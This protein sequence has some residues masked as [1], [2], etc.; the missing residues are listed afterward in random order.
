MVAAFVE[1]V[2]FGQRGEGEKMYT[3]LFTVRRCARRNRSSLASAVTFETLEIRKMLSTVSL[4]A[5]TTAVLTLAS[6][7]TLQGNGHT[8]GGVAGYDVNSVTVENLKITASRSAANNGS[9]G[10]N[11]Y[12]DKA[13]T[14]LTISNVSISGFTN[15]YGLLIGTIGSG[16]YANISISAVSAFSNGQAGI[17]T[18][19]N[20]GTITKFS[21]TNSSAYNN[22]GISNSNSPSGSGIMVAGLNGATI[23]SCI[24]YNNGSK[25]NAVSGPVGIFAYDSN[26]V[27][28]SQCYSYDNKTRMDDGGGF[29]L[30][31]GVTN[32]EIIN[33]QAWDNVGYG[34]AD[35]TYAGGAAN[36][37]NSFV[38]N[39]S[40]EDG[41]GFLVWSN[42]PAI[43]NLTVTGN[44]FL[45]PTSGYAIEQG[46]GSA[47]VSLTF[48]S[49][50]DSPGSTNEILA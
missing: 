20:T 43:S 44:Q 39:I 36:S 15:G 32:S 41:E 38:N 9:S 19:G 47:Y 45:Y 2:L 23:Q 5:N 26:A 22:P 16:T 21:L 49:N 12:S 6:G 37:G 10:I 11:I 7:E 46:T 13:I 28:I 25:N 35:F 3:P 8:V 42:G 14:G 17:S 4:T 31:G 18:Y 50:T 1:P 40:T 30:D 29:D 48:S 34:F 24:A 33:C 27:V